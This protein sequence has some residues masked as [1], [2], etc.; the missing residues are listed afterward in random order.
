MVFLEVKHVLASKLL[1]LR[2]EILKETK[3]MTFMFTV[4]TL[5][6]S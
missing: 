5:N 3:L 6:I 4:S 2:T 1:A